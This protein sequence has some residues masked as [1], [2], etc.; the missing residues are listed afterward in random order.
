MPV[1]IFSMWD[2][3]LEE[4]PPNVP[5]AQLQLPTQQATPYMRTL[6]KLQ[7]ANLLSQKFVQSQI[8]NPMLRQ[9][10][11][12]SGIIGPRQPFG[13]GQAGL[14]PE[15]L[16]KLSRLRQDV[17]VKKGD[18]TQY[19][20]REH[21]EPSGWIKLLEIFGAMNYAVAGASN[22]VV[23][24]LQGE[25]EET[26]PFLE[27]YR[28]FTLKDKEVFGDVLENLGWEG[29][30]GFAYWSRESL[31][32]V[33]DVVTDPINFIALGSPQAAHVARGIA[34]NV[35]LRNS[36]KVGGRTVK[37]TREF[38]SITQKIIREGEKNLLE[39][40]PFLLGA[41][42]ETSRRS[43]AFKE[44]VERGTGVAIDPTDPAQAVYE[45]QTGVARMHLEDSVSSEVKASF[46][47]MT[48]HN[49]GTTLRK[50]ERETRGSAEALQRLLPAIGGEN[51]GEI[52]GEILAHFLDLEGKAFTFENVKDFLTNPTGG[53]K[54]L[55]DPGGL[56]LRVPFTE[57]G[58]VIAEAQWLNSF[59]L[60]IHEGISKALGAAATITPAP[61]TQ[62][63]KHIAEGISEST[64]TASYAISRAFGA[65][66]RR[67]GVLNTLTTERKTM[68][69]NAQTKAELQTQQILTLDIGGKEVPLDQHPEL[70]PFLVETMMD[71]QYSFFDWLKSGGDLEGDEYVEKFIP[72]MVAKFNSIPELRALALEN[73]TLPTQLQDITKRIQHAFRDQYEAAIKAGV[74]V[75]FMEY[76]LPLQYSNWQSKKD[77]YLATGGELARAVGEDPFSRARLLTKQQA[78]S[79]GLRPNTNLYSLVLNRLYQFQRT[80]TERKFISS[81]I[82]QLGV[83]PGQVAGILREMYGP[84]S[85]VADEIVRSLLTESNYTDLLTEENLGTLVGGLDEFKKLLDNGSF[86]EALVW[87]EGKEDLVPLLASGEGRGRFIE[88]VSNETTAGISTLNTYLNNLIGDA[89]HGLDRAQETLSNA[90]GTSAEDIEKLMEKLGILENGAPVL[91]AALRDLLRERVERLLPGVDLGEVSAIDLF[92]R[93]SNQTFLENSARNNAQTADLAVLLNAFE[94]ATPAGRNIQSQLL[95]EVPGLEKTLDDIAKEVSETVMYARGSTEFSVIAARMEADLLTMSLT[96]LP[97]TALERF[98]AKSARIP[99]GPTNAIVVDKLQEIYTKE[100]AGKS[101]DVARLTDELLDQYGESVEINRWHREWMADHGME[102]IEAPAERPLRLELR[103]KI[104][105]SMRAAKVGADKSGLEMFRKP[106]FAPGGMTPAGRARKSG[107]QKL[108]EKISTTLGDTNRERYLT[109]LDSVVKPGTSLPGYHYDA[110]GS[111]HSAALGMYGQQASDVLNFITETAEKFKP[112]TIAQRIAIEK[113]QFSGVVRNL[114][115]GTG[116]L[117]KALERLT[118]QATKRMGDVLA[119]LPA[120]S[121]LSRKAITNFNTTLTE[122]GDSRFVKEVNISE[123]NNQIRNA[124]QTLTE[125]LQPALAS[126]QGRDMMFGMI[127]DMHDVLAESNR[128]TLGALQSARELSGELSELVAD[129]VAILNVSADQAVNYTE[130]L[131][132]LRDDVQKMLNQADEE[133]ARLLQVNNPKPSGWDQVPEEQLKADA[134][135]GTTEELNREFSL[136]GDTLEMRR[137]GEALRLANTKDNRNKIAAALKGVDEDLRKTESLVNDT[138]TEMSLVKQARHYQAIAYRELRI[139]EQANEAG[140]GLFDLNQQGVLKNYLQIAVSDEFM[141]AGDFSPAGWGAAAERIASKGSRDSV[142]GHWWRELQK[143]GG[144]NEEVF[145]DALDEIVT[146]QPLKVAD[147]QLWA[148]KRRPP[149]LG[150]PTADD[151]QGAAQAAFEAADPEFLDELGMVAPSMIASADATA[152]SSLGTFRNTESII[153]RMAD[154]AYLPDEELTQ[155]AR[156]LHYQKKFIE[157]LTS[158]LRNRRGVVEGL[159][160]VESPAGRKALANTNAELTNIYA[161]QG[162]TGSL[163]EM[164]AQAQKVSTTLMVLAATDQPRALADIQKI[165]GEG[166]DVT[167]LVALVDDAA[168]VLGNLDMS[169]KLTKLL[170]DLNSNVDD[171]FSGSVSLLDDVAGERVLGREGI[172]AFFA[173]YLRQNPNDDFAKALGFS[174]GIPT[175]IRPGDLASLEELMTSIDTTPGEPFL[176]QLQ[177]LANG[178][179]DVSSAPE[180]QKRARYWMYRLGLNYEGAAIGNAGLTISQNKTLLKGLRSYQT[181]AR[182]TKLAE[183]ATTDLTGKARKVRTD[184]ASQYEARG[185]YVNQLTYQ[186]GYIEKLEVGGPVTQTT[187]AY[188]ADDAS[189]QAFRGLQ[190]MKNY[191]NLQVRKAEHVALQ[192][193]MHTLPGRGEVNY[194]L[195][196]KQIDEVDASPEKLQE[197][198]DMR[199]AGYEPGGRGVLTPEQ[200]DA[201][202]ELST[203]RRNAIEEAGELV[204]SVAGRKVHDVLG[205]DFQHF[206]IDYESAV[207]VSQQFLRQAKERL[208]GVQKG[209]SE[210]LELVLEVGDEL[211]I[212]DSI[213]APG[214]VTD[215][216]TDLAN[217]VAQVHDYLKLVEQAP[218]TLGSVPALDLQKTELKNTLFHFFGDDSTQAAVDQKRL[219]LQAV[220]GTQNIDNLSAVEASAIL[221]YLRTH[222][223]PEITR[224]GRSSQAAL[225]N[226]E[227]RLLGLERRGLVPRHIED[228]YQRGEITRKE[229]IQEYADFA[230]EVNKDHPDYPVAVR[231]PG[232]AREVDPGWGLK[233]RDIGKPVHVPKWVADA[234]DD[235][236]RPESEV[237][238]VTRKM[239]GATDFFTNSFK[240][241][242]TLPWPAFHFRN[243][244]DAAV[245]T[246][247]G[248]GAKAL[249]PTWNRRV[250]NIMSGNA[251]EVMN[252]NGVDYTGAQLLEVFERL[253]GQV[254]FADKIGKTALNAAATDPRAFSPWASNYVLR[255]VET[256]INKFAENTATLAGKGDNFFRLSIWLDSL[257][258]G[259]G[260]GDAMHYAQKFLFDYAHGLTAF[261]RGVMRRVIPFYTFSRFNIPLQLGVMFKHPGLIS[262]LGKTHNLFSESRVDPID[263]LLPSYIR[264]QWRFG[265]KVENGQLRI[266]SGR[267]LLA[268]EELGFLG[269]LATWRGKDTPEIFFDE[270]FARLNPMLKIPVELYMGQNLYFG[271]K[272]AQDQAVRGAILDWPVVRDYLQ[273]RKVVVGKGSDARAMYR[274]N[275]YRYH[276]LNQLHFSRLYRSLNAVFGPEDGATWEGLL[277]FV[278]GLRMQSVDLGR[279]LQHLQA[280]S[281]FNQEN[282][283]K[284]LSQGDWMAVERMLGTT[285]RTEEEQVDLTTTVSALERLIEETSK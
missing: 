72:Q 171:L 15:E 155:L 166:L 100:L 89:N 228:R 135:L 270:V 5:N 11:L 215:A 140:D 114:V 141:R 188:D 137:R 84:R 159:F 136:L 62:T 226:A 14:T 280:V 86:D 45:V 10:F 76:Y 192:Q 231:F 182:G 94:E 119:Q 195:L 152:K 50:L 131:V 121:G 279:R 113:L 91:G 247:F 87:L 194:L 224:L 261:E 178:G 85:P 245:R 217:G 115:G 185:Y 120:S 19:I 272:I 47:M 187:L 246:T 64:K 61:I 128:K 110:L 7:D 39:N 268:T 99:R 278:T 16:E 149:F 219:L 18:N 146:G 32:F 139:L 102:I 129:P 109:I 193:V 285:S 282:I 105:K 196:R 26:N 199:L 125:E 240:Y 56:Q 184:L 173:D 190:A 233:G 44:A 283:R 271:T 197:I 158:Q 97:A 79:M 3:D 255:G 174:E 81:V 4:N 17:A 46:A 238:A 82:D 183:Q 49:D 250:F 88:A 266:F 220:A 277:P 103:D 163:E 202:A 66:A 145:F 249:N 20:P 167:T 41:S 57:K 27:A 37:P 225:Q 34:T 203:V 248:I 191:M 234:I 123:V 70:H 33:L 13:P 235:A 54:N 181:K 200:A 214:F 265:P 134:V 154:A 53:I 210:G 78:E 251:D 92:K 63:L 29:D 98:V 118:D 42:A 169:K 126:S 60:E 244:L 162:F 93:S 143:E 260:A 274:V 164:N 239:L 189:V 106:V 150:G 132:A 259:M 23:N 232:M 35:T 204:Y 73:T 80:Q 223:T 241:A 221:N 168:K 281:N 153:A 170:K 256:G 243:V 116:Y 111:M 284:A 133:T 273:M 209:G 22:A 253:G 160:S 95:A 172:P 144:L 211:A 151:L 59:A 257:E 58:V 12:D 177:A 28:G 262:G 83:H 180:L 104:I 258:K 227:A 208:E 30:D 24:L 186:D 254:D 48:R 229:M 96:A 122:I 205:I 218:P 40:K 117:T 67:S 201:V 2:P 8:A 269:D 21:S 51:N 112:S 71:E 157:S 147:A 107:L 263:Q 252:F 101:D 148:A 216:D 65:N 68:L 90:L 236:V 222:T 9:D 275:G 138:L 230:S 212:A 25:R 207:P 206:N 31:G 179:V 38:A 142:L 242:M 267:N 69:R 55:I 175:R 43:R 165:V 130:R 264:E 198:A 6:L 213:D 276:L 237:G 75:E 36:A 108:R 176:A 77:I 156:E 127:Q 74:E 1:G 161:T 52:T 124:F